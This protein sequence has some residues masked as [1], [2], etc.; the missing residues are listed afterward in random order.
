MIGPIQEIKS[1]KDETRGKFRAKDQTNRITR[2]RK[3]KME[4]L[5]QEIN[6]WKIK[7]RK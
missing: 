5:T 3:T 7:T 6:Q 1:G 2:T 4:K